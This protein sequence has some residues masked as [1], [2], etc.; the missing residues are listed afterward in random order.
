[1]KNWMITLLVLVLLG[2]CSFTTP[3]DQAVI[4]ANYLNAVSINAKVQTDT[5]LPA[6]AKTW[7]AAEAKTWVAMD[8]WSKGTSFAATTQPSAK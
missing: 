7:W 4:H 6:Y 5:V 1:M 2:G 3:A 8:A